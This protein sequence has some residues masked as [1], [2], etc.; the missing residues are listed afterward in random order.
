MAIQTKLCGAAGSNLTPQKMLTGQMGLSLLR[1]EYLDASAA[2]AKSYIR[3]AFNVGLC[4][5]LYSYA[6]LYIIY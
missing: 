6:L 1:W 3:V 5:Y 4:M 2:V